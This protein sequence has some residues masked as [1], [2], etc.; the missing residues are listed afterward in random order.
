MG[1]EE[2]FA[3][4]EQRFLD[5]E[6][7]ESQSDSF[8]S[9]HPEPHIDDGYV[10]ADVREQLKLADLLEGREKQKFIDILQARMAESLRQGESL[11]I[12]M[13]ML[14]AELGN[15]AGLLNKELSLAIEYAEIDSEVPETIM[16]LSK[17]N[18]PDGNMELHRLLDAITFFN[19]GVSN[20]TP[21]DEDEYEDLQYSMY[22]SQTSTYGFFSHGLG[23]LRYMQSNKLCELHVLDAI[24]SLRTATQNE[25]SDKEGVITG[26]PGGSLDEA[27]E[28]FRNVDQTM[29]YYRR[30]GIRSTYPLKHPIRQ[31]SRNYLG[32]FD[33]GKLVSVYKN[34]LLTDTEEDELVSKEEQYI[35]NNPNDFDYI[36]E[37]LE[38]SYSRYRRK[39]YDSEHSAQLY[40]LQDLWNFYDEL[41]ARDKR[42]Y[43]DMSRIDK[44]ILHP[45]VY[46]DLL[47]RN[48]EYIHAVEGV[49]DDTKPVP[50]SDFQ[51]ELFL[52]DQSKSS[53]R[54][55]GLELYKY[56]MSPG[57]RVKI[58]R[59]LGFELHDLPPSA[60]GQLL[61]Q[62]NQ[63]P[64]EDWP[65][66]ESFARRYGKEGLTTYLFLEYGEHVAGILKSITETFDEKEVEELFSYSA[67]IVQ[68]A[69]YL[70]DFFNQDKA[71]ELRAGNQIYEAIVRRTK[72]I[73]FAAHAVA[74]QGKAQALFYNR[75]ISLTSKQEIM[76]ALKTFEH[77]L[78][79]MS[80]LLDTTT[81]NEDQYDHDYRRY[82]CVYHENDK[83][84]TFVFEVNELG[85]IRHLGVQLRDYGTR[86]PNKAREFDGEARINFLFFDGD[87]NLSMDSVERKKAETLR[88]DR[89]A[90]VRRDGEVIGHDPESDDCTMSL[91]IGS[92]DSG[93]GKVIAI[94]NSISTGLEE[95]QQRKYPEYYHNRESFAKVMGEKDN[96]ASLANMVRKKITSTFTIPS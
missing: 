42:F 61:L 12:D 92:V 5:A 40:V 16:A 37:V 14:F 18:D 26:M 90:F 89:D 43:F 86:E 83:P 48:Q 15:E 50:W 46:A 56:L 88:F 29:K 45:T 31:I 13:L 38:S 75:E 68:R 96:F 91:D 10:V 47:S 53:D 34:E 55:D 19:I 41:R 79:M 52:T 85:V 63:A 49:E 2:R 64:A 35:A 67:S 73:F 23:K 93:L 22:Y 1:F 87:Y 33:S 57:I 78:M 36:Y 7:I 80:E 9:L 11:S 44:G 3:E 30:L 28:S 65:D 71:G 32:M 24:E 59:E 77:Q 72:D 20:L 81:T 82:K 17:N 25:D 6:Y 58:E 27:I 70:G 84:E 54:S 60:Q 76:E 4:D 74:L 94:G 21:H 95:T 69:E 62:I 66:I 39:G 51:R 8:E